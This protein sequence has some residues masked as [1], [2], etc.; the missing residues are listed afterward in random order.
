M[1]GVIC[2]IGV[3]KSWLTGGNI[4]FLQ[5]SVDS[6]K[7]CFLQQLW[8][9]VPTVTSLQGT[10]LPLQVAWGVPRGFS[11]LTSSCSRA[12]KRKEQLQHWF[13]LY[14]AGDDEDADIIA[15]FHSTVSLCCRSSLSCQESIRLPLHPHMASSRLMKGTAKD[16]SPGSLN[17]LTSYGNFSVV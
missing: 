17:S 2:N 9:I 7:Y 8:A 13:Y 11:L 3:M 14:C 12:N 5:P 4:C 16:R 6:A 15:E 10:G 1:S